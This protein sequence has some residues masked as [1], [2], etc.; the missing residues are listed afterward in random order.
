M[1]LGFAG[2]ERKKKPL[3]VKGTALFFS[4]FLFY[5]YHVIVWV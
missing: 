1:A 4:V 2:L 3:P 5:G